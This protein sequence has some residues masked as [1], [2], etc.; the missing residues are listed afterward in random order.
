IE[1]TLEGGDGNDQLVGSRFDDILQSGNGSDT[2]TGGRGVDIFSDSSGAGD[3]D[4]L[5]EEI[6]ADI[7]LFND[8]LF[9][10]T[11]LGDNGVDPFAKFRI[12]EEEAA[13]RAAEAAN[14]DPSKIL[15]PTISGLTDRGNVYRHDTQ[16]KAEVENLNNYFEVAFI[17]G[18]ESNNLLVLGDRNNQVK[19]GT[20]LYSNLAPWRGPV[21]FDNKHN[22]QDTY[23]EYYLI[24]LPGN[25]KARVSIADSGGTGGYDELY[26][27]G[28]TG[29][30]NFILRG[31]ASTDITA[32]IIIAG[33]ENDINHDQVNYRQ[34]ERVTISSLGGDD[35]FLSD[36]TSVVTVINMGPGNDSITVG[37]VPQK[38]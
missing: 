37:T 10:G 22:S 1:I 18:G 11:I 24:N 15:F 20:T 16:V 9:V 34:V 21:T 8:K 38:P 26:V 13:N 28:T 17:S 35:S 19:V 25:A 30:D 4:T 23:N 31:G 5:I 3:T 6:D 29:N 27:Y 33:Q 2:V 14:T 7:T 36:D 32:G 12:T